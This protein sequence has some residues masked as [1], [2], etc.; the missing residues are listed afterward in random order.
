MSC[1]DE[2]IHSWRGR[3]PIKG[4]KLIRYTASSVITTGVSFGAIVFFYGLKIIPGVIWA[5]LVGNVIATLPSY[6]LNRLWAWGKRGKSAF[7]KEIV[8]YW[9]LAF[10]GIAF[11]QIGAFRRAAIVRA[12]HWS[13]LANTGLVAGIN[14]VCFAIFW[15]LK[16]IVFNRIFH[17]DKLKVIDEELVAEEFSSIPERR[18]T[19]SGPTDVSPSPP[20]IAVAPVTI[21]AEGP[22]LRFWSCDLFLAC[23]RGPRPTRARNSFATPWSRAL[24]D[25]LVPRALGVLRPQH[26]PERHLVDARGQP[27]R[28]GPGLSTE[29]ALDLG[30]AGQEPVPQERSCRS[31]R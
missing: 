24:D 6:H 1:A 22:K 11:S 14:L 18:S 28:V 20:R 7:R 15:V 2:L 5:T 3:R 30:Q 21:R 25:R 16:L 10:A 26:H 31:G 12:H 27:R 29:P 13:H 19:P 23:E 4:K 17:F 9:S 8:P